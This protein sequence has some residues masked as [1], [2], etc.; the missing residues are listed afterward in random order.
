M[1]SFFKAKQTAILL[2][3][4]IATA[5]SANS[6]LSQSGE[7]PNWPWDQSFVKKVNLR[8]NYPMLQNTGGISASLLVGLYKLIIPTSPKTLDHHIKIFAMLL[9]FFSGFLMAKQYLRTDIGMLIFVLIMVTPGYQFVELS[10]ETIAAVFLFLFLYGFAKA[11]HP[12]FLSLILVSFGLAKVELALAAVSL[13]LYWIWTESST[14]KR[15][16]IIA[17]FLLWTFLLLFPAFIWHGKCAIVGTRALCTFGQKYCIL[18]NAHQLAPSNPWGDIQK[19]MQI[20]FP[21]AESFY[22]VVALYPRKYLDYA[23]LSI[24]NALTTMVIIFKGMPL[25]FACR[26]QFIGRSRAI[27]CLEP[28]VFISF[29]ASL[30][31]LTLISTPHAGYFPKYHLPLAVLCISYWEDCALGCTHTVGL[32]MKYL[33]LAG[34]LLTIL[35]QFLELLES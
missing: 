34:F 7:V 23:A 18:F 12:V 19:M 17:S 9:F 5:I 20:A 21:K 29:I 24:V 14:G 15:K 31:P 26:M 11:W 25:A 13:V 4:V 33:I 10:N 35:W 2:V 27:R 6:I 22:D 1:G 30:L 32:R 16:L 28:L 8:A 3:L